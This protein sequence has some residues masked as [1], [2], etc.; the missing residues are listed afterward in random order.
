[1]DMWD[2]V[3]RCAELVSTVAT[4]PYAWA[5]L[6]P[7]LLTISY[8]ELR[9][10]WD[11]RPGRRLLAVTWNGNRSTIEERLA[12]GLFEEDDHDTVRAIAAQ[13]RKLSRPAVEKKSPEEAVAV[14]RQVADELLVEHLKSRE[15]R[16]RGP[17]WRRPFRRPARPLPDGTSRPSL[18]PPGSDLA[19]L[20]EV[21]AHM[22]W[23]ERLRYAEEYWA[24]PDDPM[25]F[26]EPQPEQ[27]P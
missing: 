11:G 22:P 7:A 8:L 9:R 4:D 5:P 14:W 3:R 21:V 23:P 2:L 6:V 10:W 25:P 20:R 16:L 12:R 19:A 15:R 26:G 24:Q 1:M 18:L 17:W 27:G 13:V